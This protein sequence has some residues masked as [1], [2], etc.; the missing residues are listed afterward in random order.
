MDIKLHP[1]QV[2]GRITIP[3]S[4][5]Q[6]IRALLLATFA[7]GTSIIR[8]PLDS[9]DTR[10]CM[11]ACRAFGAQLTRLPSYEG[12]T[13]AIRVESP[14]F[15]T[16]DVVIDCGNSGT[17][18]YLATA[19]AAASPHTVTFTGDFQLRKRP[20]GNLLA[21]LGDLG[22][23]VEYLA[24]GGVPLYPPF[25]IRGP[26]DGGKTSIECPTSQFMSGLLL[27]LP[28]A[29]GDSEIIAPLLNEKPYV[30]LTLAWL[31]SQGIAYTCSDDLQ[32]VVMQGRQHYHPFDSLVTGDFS[33]AAFFFCAAAISG[34]SI[35]VEGLD[36][37]DPQGDKQ[38][39]VILQNMGCHVQWNGTTV[40]VTG[41]SRGALRGGD[42]DLNSMP[43][44]LPALAVTAC[45]AHGTTRLGNVPQARIKETDRIAVMHTNLSALGAD[46]DESEDALV[47]HGNGTLRGG[48]CDGF[49]DHRIIMSMAVAA[50]ACEQPVTIHGTDAVEVTFP[51]FFKLFKHIGAEYEYL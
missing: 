22:A 32:H 2:W 35:T 12:R 6:T 39:L 9:Q 34:T 4:K 19:L 45:F 38:I 43:D 31:D 13:D 36:L 51:T 23:Q 5:S 1:T 11:D 17:T 18:L 7:K 37:N 21:A 50:L 28:L 41:P 26:L 48:V 44:A 30:R 15:P 25:T 42:F 14:G 27:G 3:S 46:I 33:S 47:I 24:D 16:H 20:V 49:E 10:S 40:T 8:N 29:A